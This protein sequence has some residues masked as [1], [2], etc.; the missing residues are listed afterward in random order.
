MRNL[1]KSSTVGVVTAVVL[2][3]GAC[4]TGDETPSGFCREVREL[5]EEFTGDDDDAAFASELADLNAP[6]E[7]EEEWETVVGDWDE[8]ADPDEEELAAEAGDIEAAEELEQ[9][10]LE[11]ERSSR[12]VTSYLRD[13]CGFELE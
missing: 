11:F 9:R 5:D 3:A 8:F 10:A 4:G 13:E 1:L 7:I 12:A 6:E 2:V